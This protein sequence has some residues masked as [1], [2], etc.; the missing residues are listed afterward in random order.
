MIGVRFCP[1]RG[2]WKAAILVDGMEEVMGYWV[3][4]KKAQLAYD[5]KA[6]EY[7][8]DN[9]LTNFPLD[10]EQETEVE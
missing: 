2:K 7:F 10:R 6:R 5:Q 3:D 1:T 4:V 8:G 9:V